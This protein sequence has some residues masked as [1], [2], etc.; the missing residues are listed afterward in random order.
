MD[1]VSSPISRG[2][3]LLSPVRQKKLLDELV[4]G[5]LQRG[6]LL[7]KRQTYCAAFCSSHSRK[8]RPDAIEAAIIRFSEGVR[9]RAEHIADLKCDADEYPRH[10][11]RCMRGS[12]VSATHLDDLEENVNMLGVL[13]GDLWALT[14][15]GCILL[16]R[17]VFDQKPKWEEE[18]RE[19]RL[20]FMNQD[21]LIS[22][23]MDSYE[24]VAAIAGEIQWEHDTF[25]WESMDERKMVSKGLHHGGKQALDESQYDTRSFGLGNESIAILKFQN[26]HLL[27]RFLTL[28]DERVSTVLNNPTPPLDKSNIETL[29]KTLP[30]PDT[31]PASSSTFVATS[32]PVPEPEC[33]VRPVIRHKGFPTTSAPVPE[34][35][36][37]AKPVIRHKGPG[38]PSHKMTKENLDTLLLHQQKAQA[39]V[40]I[41]LPKFEPVIDGWNWSSW[42]GSRAT[43]TVPLSVPKIHLRDDIRNEPELPKEV[44]GCNPPAEVEESDPPAEREEADP[45]AKVEKSDVPADVGGGKPPAEV[46]S[47][48]PS[49]TH[50]RVG[51][52]PNQS[53]RTLIPPVQL[54]VVPQTEAKTAK[55]KEAPAAKKGTKNDADLLHEKA[56]ATQEERVR[57]EKEEHERAL[58]EKEEHERALREEEEHKKKRLI[59][60]PSQ[61]MVV[62]EGC[63]PFITKAKQ[64]LKMR[65]M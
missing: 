21:S 59:K 41:E 12:R 10:P 25:Y 45:L 4:A 1:A 44:K 18:K 34:P 14:S 53:G 9:I 52:L 2:W 27:Q 39:D 23:T 64:D 49:S 32:A 17:L 33:K 60:S 51:W 31:E 57:R 28:Q 56:R 7:S 47:K 58:K 26:K 36:R 50:L 20:V 16:Q 63:L 54:A 62:L 19:M 38:K 15:A 40:K 48:K 43:A 35:E 46:T 61:L 37:K 3:R 55:Q 65:P 30:C 13:I 8:Q 29:Q 42:Q 11:G 6:S 24:R 5:L 22:Q